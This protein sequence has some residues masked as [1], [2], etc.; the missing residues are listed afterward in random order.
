MGFPN[1]ESGGRHGHRLI[2]VKKIRRPERGAG[3]RYSDRGCGGGAAA[4]HGRI[5]SGRDGIAQAKKACGCN[6]MEIGR[7][8][9]PS[10]YTDG[11]G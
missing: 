3:R 7:A 4:I 8:A 1:R 5:Q 6:R 11:H 9:V 2:Q 10:D